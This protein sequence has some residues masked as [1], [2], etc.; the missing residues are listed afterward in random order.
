MI[1]LGVLGVGDIADKMV[2]GLLRGPDADGIAV[3]LSPRGAEKTRALVAELPCCVMQD[4]QAV[5]D[6]ADVVLVSVR[7][8]QVADL[9]R[10]VVLRCDQKLVS[11]VSG[12]PVRELSRLFGTGWCFRAMPSYAAEIGC[13]TIAVYP[14]DP[15]VC[16][17]LRRLGSPVILANEREFELATVGASMNGWLYFLLHD[18]QHWLVEKGLPP[19]HARTLVLGSVADCVAYAR[20][21][22]SLSMR[23][24]GCSIA[25]SGTFTAQGLEML[26][27]H[28]A[29]AAW[30][31]ACEVVLDGLLARFETDAHWGADRIS[32]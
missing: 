19:D 22:D 29:N 7:P 11:V 32:R 6:A 8:G 17:V 31:A 28:Q 4:N 23:D 12:V 15:D 9:A 18:L 21:H 25:T 14:S 20:H 13:S 30:S 24:L 10:E 16:E 2:R 26:G 5:V 27:L 3:F 1:K